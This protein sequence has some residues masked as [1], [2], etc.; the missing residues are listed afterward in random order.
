MSHEAPFVVLIVTVAV[1]PWATQPGAFVTLTANAGAA[2]GSEAGSSDAR[3][4]VASGSSVASRLR[5]RQ[6]PGR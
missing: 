4:S 2:G 1:P 6:A 3:F 5:D